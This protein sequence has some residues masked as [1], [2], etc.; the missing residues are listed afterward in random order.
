[1]GLGGKGKHQFS[2]WW[3]PGGMCCSMRSRGKSGESELENGKAS[4]IGSLY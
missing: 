1:M 4:K 3:R 2:P